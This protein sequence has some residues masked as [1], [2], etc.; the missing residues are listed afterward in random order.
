MCLHEVRGPREL[1]AVGA[2]VVAL[3]ADQ[4]G[5]VVGQGDQGG[6]G[7]VGDLNLMYRVL[8]INP[9][10]IALELTGFGWHIC[11]NE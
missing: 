8:Q 10:E 7:G 11:L 5:L 4:D 3:G 1:Y 9:E 6:Q 2:E